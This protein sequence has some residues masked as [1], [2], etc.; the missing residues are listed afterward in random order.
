MA[1]FDRHRPE[2]VLD[3]LRL[4]T[5][6]L[7][8][9]RGIAGSTALEM[10][11]AVRDSQD[12][13]ARAYVDVVRQMEDALDAVLKDDYKT[14]FFNAVSMYE[15]AIR[16]KAFNVQTRA[17][18]GSAKGGK[19]RAESIRKD[20]AKRN[21]LIKRLRTEAL[22]LNAIAQRADCSISTVS[23]VLNPKETVRPKQ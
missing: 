12:P 21:A 20:N 11:P 10:W 18:R 16:I 5:L 3:R 6:G 8:H 2:I 9:A 17:R 4:N 19:K 22:S 14:A 1:Q 7:I 23:R 15:H 13:L